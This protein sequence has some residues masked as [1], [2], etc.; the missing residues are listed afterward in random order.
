MGTK[1]DDA[2]RTKE[3]RDSND[4]HYKVRTE[5]AREAVYKHGKGVKSTVVERLLAED[6][7]VPT[8]VCP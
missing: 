8:E 5:I 6:S 4:I 1:R 3:A 7:L 2:R